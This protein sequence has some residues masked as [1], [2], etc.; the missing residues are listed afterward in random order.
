MSCLYFKRGERGLLF[1][2][3]IILRRQT[4]LRRLL[5]GAMFG[6]LTIL[7]MFIEIGSLLLFLLKIIVSVIMVV[8][9]FGYKKTNAI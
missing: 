4:T 3:G 9:V 8:I 6:S 2:V 5:L 7:F 1:G